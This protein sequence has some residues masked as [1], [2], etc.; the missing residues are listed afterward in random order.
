M[1]PAPF[2]P[3]RC[4]SRWRHEQHRLN[5]DKIAT[6]A[7]VL[8]I[9]PEDLWRSPAQQRRRHYIREWR[10]FRGLTLEQ[11]AQRAGMSAGNLSQLERGAQGYSAEGLALHWQIFGGTGFPNQFFSDSWVVGFWRGRPWLARYRIGETNSDA[12]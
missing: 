3:P 10:K 12:G 1:G 8:G 7:S 6:L 2:S 4:C 5:P 11:V 9:E